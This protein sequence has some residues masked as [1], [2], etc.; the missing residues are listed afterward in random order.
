[1]SDEDQEI[2]DLFFQEANDYFNSIESILLEFDAED[3]ATFEVDERV[4]TLFRS[5]HSLKGA[6]AMVGFLRINQYAHRC[7]N[8]LDSVRENQIILN[9]EV[10]SALFD[11]LDVIRKLFDEAQSGEE[12]LDLDA[13]IK[14]IDSCLENQKNL[15]TQKI[16]KEQLVVQ[17]DA[18]DA[19]LRIEKYLSAFVADTEENLGKIEELLLS[20]EG[21]LVENSEWR[22]PKDVV[23]EIF[24]NAHGIKGAAGTMGFV[25][26]SE[27]THHIEQVFSKMR[28]EELSIDSGLLG[29]LL[30]SLDFIK[31]FLIRVQEEDFTE[32]DNSKIL[33]G[34]ARFS[35]LALSEVFSSQA[36]AKVFSGDFSDEIL[37][38][39]DSLKRAGH[40]ILVIEVGISESERL[41][42]MKAFLI[43]TKLQENTD[44]I[45][46]DKP[47]E[48][49]VN[50]DSVYEFRF[51]IDTDFN[52][53]QIK[54]LIRIDGL[55]SIEIKKWEL[56]SDQNGLPEKAPAAQVAK[57]G[58][59]NKAAAHP[60]TMR[61]DVDR[62][63][64]LM[65]MSGE[66]VINKSR[67][68]QI[69]QQLREILDCRYLTSRAQSFARDLQNTSMMP[70]LDNPETKALKARLD[71]LQQEYEYILNSLNEMKKAKAVY[72]SFEE[73][74]HQLDLA[75]A[76][77]QQSIMKIR[78]VPIGPLFGRMKRIVRDVC[79]ELNKD[80]KLELV[81]EDTELDKRMID[82]LVDP[83]T[84]IVRNALDHGIEDKDQRQQTNK[85]QKAR[86]ELA[87]FQRGNAFCL[88]ISDD[89]RGLNLERIKQKAIENNILSED[90]LNKLSKKQVCELIFHPGF[91]T[92][93]KVTSI[94]GRGVGMDIVKKKID[95]LNGYVEIDT[96]EGQG[97]SFTIALPLTLAV[98]KTLLCRVQKDVYA[99]PLELVSEIIHATEKDVYEI[100][101]EPV[102]RVRD[103]VIAVRGFSDFF[104]KSHFAR[105]EKSKTDL[106]LVIVE[107][108][109][110]QIAIPV[111]SLMGEEDIVVKSLTQNLGNIS[112][113][114]GATIMGDGR[115]ALIIDVMGLVD[116]HLKS[117]TMDEREGHA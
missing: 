43:A 59:Q 76:S 64:N 35:G 57:Q 65:N 34:L 11:S 83:L 62:L 67:F 85:D 28:D 87:A 44:F 18:G 66:L 60:Q 93:A 22:M 7:E 63:D 56:Q 36:S 96:E 5:F 95:E 13:S 79:K 117:G 12:T 92:A 112:G 52:D 105:G 15:E 90:A 20:A 104:K 103:R 50:L 19:A 114:S 89:G 9:K 115:V 10:I 29:V 3:A 25:A 45:G 97:T 106:T 17:S 73:A 86:L 21:S 101:K 78:M 113:L 48:E 58:Q 107:H 54:D 77:I 2:I 37:A 91:S 116:M 61:I 42:G 102:V 74:L 41:P 71:F 51:L 8:L 99:F 46:S 6:S 27:V 100:R 4:H 53:L 39:A 24:R 82:D 31:N 69:N 70:E 26:L 55:G 109:G 68:L 30:E 88:R 72:L 49:L 108:R 47:V 23:D 14:V 110:E 1:M 84:H 80:V 111:D 98:Q 16:V 81:G 94:S 40:R 33:K 75:S 38:A 32:E